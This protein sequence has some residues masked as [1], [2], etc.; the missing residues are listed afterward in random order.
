MKNWTSVRMCVCVY[1]F[2]N[3]YCYHYINGLMFC[4]L[5]QMKIGGDPVVKDSYSVFFSYLLQ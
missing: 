5:T 1:H 2:Y 3:Q 4:R